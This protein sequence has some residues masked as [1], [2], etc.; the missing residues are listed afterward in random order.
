MTDHLIS[1]E[2]LELIPART[3]QIFVGKK[4]GH[5]SASQEKI[6]ALLIEYAS[7]GYNVARLRNNFV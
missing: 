5:H 2:I 4:K 6:N 1:Q 3:M 7:K